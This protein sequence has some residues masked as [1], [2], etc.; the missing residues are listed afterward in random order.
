MASIFGV[1]EYVLKSGVHP[2][3]FEKAVVRARKR[4]LFKL[5]GLVDYYFLR[6]VK[7]RRRGSYAAVWVFESREAWERLWGTAD[8]PIG[9]EGYPDNWKIWENEILAPLL[10]RD[11]DT[12]T[13]TD[14]EEI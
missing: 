3:E 12:I 1:H 2:N 10:D 8:R 4:G 11:P 14:Y 6:G 5:P 13:F 7:G 9:K